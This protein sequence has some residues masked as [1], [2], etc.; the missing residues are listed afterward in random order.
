MTK[1]AK[2]RDNQA[3]TNLFF[4]LLKWRAHVRDG[5]AGDREGLTSHVLFQQLLKTQVII[6][7]NLHFTKKGAITCHH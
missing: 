6:N 4:I 5:G 1:I 7:H 3:K 2:L